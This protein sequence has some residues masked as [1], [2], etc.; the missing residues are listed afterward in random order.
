MKT[1]IP[2]PQKSKSIRLAALLAAAGLAPQAAAQFRA[3]PDMGFFITSV[4][5][6]KGA[7]LGGRDGADAH[8]QKLADAVGAGS[9]TWHA[10]LST[11]ARGGGTQSHARDRIGLGPWR[12][13]KG[14]MVA[15]SLAELHGKNKLSKENSLTEK[16]TIVNGRGDSPNQH[17]ILTGTRADGTAYGPAEDSTCGNWTSESAGRA[18]VGHHDRHGVASNID[19]TSWVE[20]HLSNGCSQSNLVGTGGN[21]YFYCFASDVPSNR[22]GEKG[23]LPGRSVA[24]FS[25]L[26]DGAGSTIW[27]GRLEASAGMTLDILTLAGERIALV[28]TG[29]LP[30][31]SH[32]IT[33]NGLAASGAPAP[34]GFYLV[35]LIRH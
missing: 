11:Q 10:Y 31:G 23:A 22:L 14:V 34:R 17:D 26:W 3:D 9:R 13:S 1:T 8:C 19:S 24:G 7:N 16:G 20:A 28:E 30:A 18:M 21:G 5:L 35:R 2:H 33:W 32:E 25:L 29:P 12:N 15:A 27:K 4:G 6:G